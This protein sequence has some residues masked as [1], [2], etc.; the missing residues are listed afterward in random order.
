M[1]I[2]LSL[3]FMFALAWSSAVY[4]ELLCSYDDQPLLRDTETLSCSSF[5]GISLAST[6]QDV[7]QI[8][9]S[10]GFDVDTLFYVGSQS[11][12]SGINI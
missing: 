6:P 8:A 10:L 7:K 9:R 12:V 11:V 2:A 1:R 4:G 3:S 5:R